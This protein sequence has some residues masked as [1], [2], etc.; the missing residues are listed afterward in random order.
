MSRFPLDPPVIQTQDIERRFQGGGLQVMAVNGVSLDI[1][2]GELLVI[3]GRSGSGKTTLL[4]LLGG[5]DRPTSGTILWQ[6]QDTG[7]MSEKEFTRWRRQ[8]V[9]FVFQS[10]G[11]LPLLSA[12]ENVDLA[13]RIRGV[14]GQ[15][16]RQ[17]AL[18]ALKDV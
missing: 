10:F 17:K 18:D 6:G 11:L 2:Q 3:M 8:N 1:R 7:A 16:R 4:N 13:L 12:F 14:K 5:L 15:E 9:G